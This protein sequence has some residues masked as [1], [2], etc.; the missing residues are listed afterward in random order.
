MRRV[1]L[2]VA[3]G[4]AACEAVQPPVIEG[5][6][7]LPA[8]AG[9]AA[10]PRIDGPVGQTTGAGTPQISTGRIPAAPT[11]ATDAA[12]P[13]GDISLDFVDTDIR[14]IA[15]Q[16]LGTILRVN[17]SIDPTV[18]GTATLR[19]VN[20]ISR[21]R[22]LPAL[23][24]LLVQNGATVVQS[25]GLYRVTTVASAAASPGLAGAGTAGGAL[26]PLRYASAD[27]LAKLLQP[28]AGATGRVASDPGRNTL[29]ISGDPG[30]REA[31]ITLA[32]AFDINALAGQSYALFP[33]PSGSA[34]DFATAL[35]E[36]MRSGQGGALAGV[37]RVVPMDR[38]SSVLV[39]SPQA[40]YL[41]DARRVYGLVEKVQR[42]T[43]RGWNVYYLQNS[44]SNDIA[45]V[46][47]QAFT[48]NRVTAVPS[49]RATG[50]SS[51]R[52][53]GANSFNSGGGAGGAGGGLRGGGGG[54]LGGGGLGGGGLGG[55]GLGGGGLGGGGLGGGGLAQAGGADSPPAGQNPANPLLGGLEPGGGTST[56]GGG[57]DSDLNS[58]RII[59]NAEN[60]AILL[61]ATAQERDTI[62][63][64]LRKIDILPLQVRIDAVIAEVTLNDNLSYG[65]QFFFKGGGING[66]L[67]FNAQGSAAN[68]LLNNFPGFLLSG[69]NNATYAI[70][71]LQNVT[72]V[73][74]LSSPQLL[75]LDNESAR[76][77]VGN[78]VPFLTTSSQSTLTTGA[79]VINS[80]DYRE[81]GVIMEVT[82]RVNSGGL[83]TLDI[84]QEVSDVDTTATNNSAIQSPT[85]LER[86]VR[87][88]VVVQDGQ[89]VGLAG[90]IRDNASGGN[91]G[92][93]WL[94]DVPILGLLAGAQSNTRSRTELLVLVTPHVVRDQRDARALTEDLRDQLINAAAI[95][96]QLQNQGQS[97]SPDP[98]RRLR[99][100]L[101]LEQ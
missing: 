23:Q 32:Q 81:T 46:L 21:A 37:V 50:A 42:Q 16:V 96:G 63:A 80:I 95:P 62:E 75:V 17:Y 101:R 85:F 29:I 69:A 71:A 53:G 35:S 98:Q 99:R 40:R 100:A 64:M 87:S 90:L 76:L 19:T 7:A 52:S 22:V 8:A 89:T 20:P 10:A 14:E 97:G 31:L 6:P 49:A 82:P 1:V 2:A 93:P 92:I 27:D 34:K 3:L 12:E 66:A 48:P 4:V 72:T 73:K 59:P 26:I 30:T 25:G 60:N 43:I 94:K 13:G 61:Y 91:Q 33:V 70:N 88:R 74:V 86:N 51:R 83:V 58:I 39:V 68:A 65:T 54:G 45:Y 41:D 47:Q 11:L 57:A 18:R 56:A 9:G 38:I 67:N 77:Q 5:L 44:K 15:S 28:Y 84:A 24:S 78:L 36:A 55:G 79:P